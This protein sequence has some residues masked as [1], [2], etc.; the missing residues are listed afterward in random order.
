MNETV[1]RL[2]L[3]TKGKGDRPMKKPMFALTS[4]GTTVLGAVPSAWAQYGGFGGD[5]V[6]S[7]LDRT[8]N[9]LQGAA[10]LIL[11]I[12]VLLNLIRMGKDDEEGPRAKK[13]VVTGMVAIGGVML[14]RGLVRLVQNLTSS[15]FTIW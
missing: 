3:K 2:L 9:W 5:E 14:L 10:I 6:T 15:T 1:A 13:H 4:F 11:S 8:I 12:Y 7:T